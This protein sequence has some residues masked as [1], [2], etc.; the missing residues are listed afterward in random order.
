[1]LHTLIV[2]LGRSGRGLHVPSLAK[3]RATAR[4]LFAPGPVMGHDPFRAGAEGVTSVPSLEEAVRRR[5]P[6]S[7][8]VHPTT[9]HPARSP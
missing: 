9:V 4:G 6:G 5:P 3:A 8:V 7:T 2:G 1:M